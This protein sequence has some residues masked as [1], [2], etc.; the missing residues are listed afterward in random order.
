MNA[1][2]RSP[3]HPNGGCIFADPFD[4]LQPEDAN[5][6]GSGGGDRE[7]RELELITVLVLAARDMGIYDIGE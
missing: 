3:K 7:R 5:I 4:I 6:K 1:Y 2:F